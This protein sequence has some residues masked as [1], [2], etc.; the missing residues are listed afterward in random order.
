MAST[1]AAIPA[2]SPFAEEVHDRARFWPWPTSSAWQVQAGGPPASA[3]SSLF[4]VPSLWTSSF[5]RDAQFAA[6]SSADRARHAGRSRLDR[7]EPRAPGRSPGRTPRAGRGDLPGVVHGRALPRLRRRQDPRACRPRLETRSSR[8]SGAPASVARRWLTDPEG[9]GP[10][11]TTPHNERRAVLTT[12]FLRQP[13]WNTFQC[14]RRRPRLLPA[15]LRIWL[16]P[17]LEHASP[18]AV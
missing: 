18:R 2:L 8:S 17:D 13:E 1:V 6:A 9:Q 11:R 15:S 5:V 14:T 4:S 3:V 12:A 7:F 10:R 16:T